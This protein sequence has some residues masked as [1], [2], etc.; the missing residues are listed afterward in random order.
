MSWPSSCEL[1]S[2]PPV[3]HIYASMNWVS[4]GSGNGLSLVWHQ[5]ITWTNAGLLLIGLLGINFSEIQIRILSFSFKKMHLKL[6]SAKMAAIFVG[7]GGG[8]GEWLSIFWWNCWWLRCSWSIT[9]LH[10]S[11][12]IFILN[13][14]PSFNGLMSKDNCKTRQEIFKFWDLVCLL[15][16]NGVVLNRQQAITQT[17]NDSVCWFAY[18]SPGLSELINGRFL[19]M[20]ISF[21]IEETWEHIDGFVQNCSISNVLGMEI[22]QSCT[23]PSISPCAGRRVNTTDEEMLDEVVCGFIPRTSKFHRYLLPFTGL[24]APCTGIYT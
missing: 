7:G 2:S 12:Y 11:N 19:F 4:I 17:N 14:T 3:L 22:L 5:A 16:G 21:C 23:K 10:C 18:A 8:G 6:S 15:S 24:L 9:C 1:N 13:L 20:Y